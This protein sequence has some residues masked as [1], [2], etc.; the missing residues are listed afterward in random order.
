MTLNIE[1]P[2]ET[3]RVSKALSNGGTV[4]MQLEETFWARRFAMF[5]DRFGMAWINDPATSR[6][7]MK[8]TAKTR[9]SS[10]RR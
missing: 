10:E 2:E 4:H 3:E 1:T 5:T 6:F 7:T 9:G 8:A